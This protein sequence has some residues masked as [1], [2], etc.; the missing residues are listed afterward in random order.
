MHWYRNIWESVCQRNSWFWNIIAFEILVIFTGTTYVFVWAVDRLKTQN[1]NKTETKW[2]K[3]KCFLWEFDA[4]RVVS[5]HIE[6]YCYYK[7]KVELI[8]LFIP[9]QTLC[10]SLHILKYIKKCAKHKMFDKLFDT[11]DRINNI[12]LVACHTV[13]PKQKSYTGTKR[14]NGRQKTNE[15]EWNSNKR[16]YAN[17][18]KLFLREKKVCDWH[19]HGKIVFET[20]DMLIVLTWIE[21][22]L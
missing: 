14:L 6:Y 1:E 2:E 19:E 3:K 11:F 10:L 8:S 9:S 21:F 7:K 20:I 12:E 18:L 16:L 4:R 15:Y 17:I 13:T 5:I 22:M